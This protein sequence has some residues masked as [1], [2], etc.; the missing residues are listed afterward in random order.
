[1]IGGATRSQAQ[2]IIEEKQKKRRALRK[3]TTS[4]GFDLSCRPQCIPNRPLRDSR[5]EIE[6][7]SSLVSTNAECIKTHHND[8]QLVRRLRDEGR[9]LEPLRDYHKDE[10]RELGQAL[11]HTSHH[12]PLAAITITAAT[13]D[14]PELARAMQS[15]CLERSFETRRRVRIVDVDK[16][17]AIINRRIDPLHTSGRCVDLAD[18]RARFVD[19]YVIAK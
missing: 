8:T 17:R 9:I 18:Y 19:G 12:G 7:A 15:Q 13:K 5:P 2:Q 3:S 14:T 10:V 6:S 4:S 1:M 11:G 16:W